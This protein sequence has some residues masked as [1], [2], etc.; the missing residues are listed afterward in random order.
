MQELSRNEVEEVSGGLIDPLTVLIVVGI[1]CFAVGVY[2]GYQAAEQ[3][4]HAH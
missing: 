3:A 4:A 1:V 2:N